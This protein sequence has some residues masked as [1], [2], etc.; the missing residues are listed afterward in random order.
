MLSEHRPIQLLEPRARGR[1][2]SVW[3]AQLNPDGEVAVKVFEL[4]EKESWLVEQDIFN[5][6]IME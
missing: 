3:R 1:F 5:V 6:S 4:Q 2:G